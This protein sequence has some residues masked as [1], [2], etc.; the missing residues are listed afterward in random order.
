MSPL[1]QEVMFWFSVGSAT[2]LFVIAAMF[3]LAAATPGLG[4][5]AT[6]ARAVAHGVDAIID[7]SRKDEITRQSDDR[8]LLP[9][10]GVLI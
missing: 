9:P 8:R 3:A 2:A 4:G 5:A 10:K 6:I 7:V 1:M